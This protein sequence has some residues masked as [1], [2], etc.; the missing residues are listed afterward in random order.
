MTFNYLYFRQQ[1]SMF[2]AE[3]AACEPSRQAHLGLA[4]GYLSRI[5][6][7]KAGRADPR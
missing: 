3:Q 1:V 7:A 2:R 5:A 6:E 4:A